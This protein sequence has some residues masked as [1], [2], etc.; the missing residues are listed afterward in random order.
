[1]LSV[2]SVVFKLQRKTLKSYYNADNSIL[3]I[4]NLHL[5]K[6]GTRE[7]FRKR[8]QIRMEGQIGLL[9]SWVFWL[10][11]CWFVGL[12]GCWVDGLLGCW[13]V[14]LMGCWVV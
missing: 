3:F 6:P 9:G 2:K 5:N 14:R 4:R 7:G 11:G 12:F 8:L 13:V 1:M 10:M